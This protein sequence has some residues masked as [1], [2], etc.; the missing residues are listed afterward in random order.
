MKC[1]IDIFKH[2]RSNRIKI[3]AYKDKK[4]NMEKDKFETTDEFINRRFGQIR[5]IDV[6]L[7]GIFDYD[8]DEK[9]L[10]LKEKF[11]IK[12]AGDWNVRTIIFDKWENIEDVKI[13]RDEL[14]NLYKKFYPM[15][16]INFKYI[17]EFENPHK[18]NI[19]GEGYYVEAKKIIIYNKEMFKKPKILFS[20]KIN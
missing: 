9:I 11:N 3:N 8:A 20:L 10:E 14:K 19:S 13:N 16:R 6:P 4:I 1:I 17:K 7:F 18:L 15:V 12:Y 5:Y 2:F